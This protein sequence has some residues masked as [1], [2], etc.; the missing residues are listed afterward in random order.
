MKQP[1]ALPL[2]LLLCL[3]VATIP[4]HAQQIQE[5]IPE[6]RDATYVIEEIE[7]SIHGRTRQWAIESFLN[8]QE[9]TR[10]ESRVAL[11][12]AM[13]ERSLR[14]NNQRMLQES[15][16]EYTIGEP[17]AGQSQPR[18][19]VTVRVHVDDSW[20]LILLPYAKY[21]SNTG[22]LVSLRGRDYNFLGTMQ[23]LAVN[24][25]YEFTEDQENVWGLSTEFSLPFQFLGQHWTF[26]VEQ[27]VS[28][29]PNDQVEWDIETSL[30]YHFSRLLDWTIT[31]E[32]GY[33]LDSDDSQFYT[34]GVR[35]STQIDTGLELPIL[36]PLT[37]NPESHAT[38]EYEPIRALQPDEEGWVL[39]LTH[40]LS[41]ERVNWVRNFRRGMG[42]NL[43]NENEYHVHERRWD[44]S[45][46]G[47]LLGH[48]PFA[49]FS[50]SGRVQGKLEI[51]QPNDE[52]AG[53]I[54]GI[55]NDRMEG[56]TAIYWN[57][58]LTLRAFRFPGFLEGHGAIFYDGAIVTE[59]GHPFD[60]RE[61]FKQGVGIEAIGF[62]LFARSLFLRA[63]F[64]VDLGAVLRE[65]SL[66]DPEHREIFIGLGHH[67]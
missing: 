63:S 42:V 12:A 6:P 50:F 3:F 41:A 33:E 40:V 47:T 66:E 15:R 43:V 25:D 8:L 24:L 36:G 55:L 64:G 57:S 1:T 9:G 52:A 62:P 45:I 31:Y 14:L 5:E 17:A 51:D 10:F 30:A 18:L 59:R 54:R 38:Y 39:G 2:A 34:S 58:D 11:E 4:L 13:Q 7:Y 61:D 46:E 20:N 53:P 67:Y 29:E 37:Y 19:P 35:L 26:G 21:D 16:I 28:V 60:R 27:A 22:L 56:D 49:P 48:W 44:R 65:G 23:E 32:Q